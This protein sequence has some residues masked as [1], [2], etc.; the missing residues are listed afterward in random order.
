MNEIQCMST[1]DVDGDQPHLET[2]M[3]KPVPLDV[4]E[5]K[6]CTPHVAAN[7]ISDLCSHGTLVKHGAPSPFGSYQASD[8]PCRKH[9]FR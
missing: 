8:L 6:F 9:K 7:E 2:R 4:F 3:K 5:V 1:Y